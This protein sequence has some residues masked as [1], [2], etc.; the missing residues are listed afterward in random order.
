V[1]APVAATAIALV[2]R[3]AVEARPGVDEPDAGRSGLLRGRFLAACTANA[4]GN[5]AQYTILLA[6]PL[7]LDER[8]WSSSQIGLVLLGMTAGMVLLNPRGG[9]LGDRVGHARPVVLGMSVLTAGAA[10]LAVVGGEVPVALVVAV[11]LTGIG[12]GLSNASL[13][14]AALEAVPERVVG[15]A[16]GLFATSRYVGSITG[17]L[18]LAALGPRAVLVVCAVAGAGAVLSGRGIGAPAVA[19]AHR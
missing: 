18:A 17:S 14:A 12:T 2:A 6:V 11:A 3:I 16:A 4:S 13:Q 9:A 10:L 15:A 7:L 8:S 19:S 1:N 5:L